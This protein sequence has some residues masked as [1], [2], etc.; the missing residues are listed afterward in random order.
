MEFVDDCWQVVHRSFAGDV[1]AGTAGVGLFLATLHSLRPDSLFADTARGAFRHAFERD[2]KPSGFHGGAPGIAYAAHRA[3]TLLDDDSLLRKAAAALDRIADAAP[4][5]EVDFLNGA[6]GTIIALVRAG[7]DRIAAAV[8][9]GDHVIARANRGDRGWSW[10]GIP[11]AHDLTGLSHGAAGIALA[12]L[13]IH[14]ATGEARFRDAAFEAFRYERSWLSPAQR[15]WPDFR[16]GVA[17]AIAGEMFG[18]GISWCHGAPGIG[19]ARLR[20]YELT[21]DADL[22]ADAEVALQTTYSALTSGSPAAGFS[23]CHGAAGN[24]ELFLVAA[25]ILDQPSLRAIGEHVANTGREL[26]HDGRRPW[27]CG[28]N[29]GGETPGLMLGLAGIGYFFL[30]AA[31]PSRIPTILF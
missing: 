19:F 31:D 18:Y 9:L 22:R 12:L 21:G 3:A 24:A 20:A 26:Y 8:R 29:G 28:V 15:N 1:Y 30:R 23:L 25:S 14:H 2:G 13:E 16:E 17:P 27:P 11:A 7:G 6:A 4:G 10:S 5:D